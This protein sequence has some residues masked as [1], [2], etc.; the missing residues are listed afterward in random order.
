LLEFSLHHLVARRK[1]YVAPDAFDVGFGE[2]SFHLI[3]KLL[4]Y[5]VVFQNRDDQDFY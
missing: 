1:D 5:K 4:A 2:Q 3:L